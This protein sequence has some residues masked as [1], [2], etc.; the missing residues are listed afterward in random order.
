MEPQQRKLLELFTHAGIRPN[1]DF[2]NEQDTICKH[3]R[4]PG[5]EQYNRWEE[6]CWNKRGTMKSHK[7]YRYCIVANINNFKLSLK[8]A[9]YNLMKSNTNELREENINIKNYSNDNDNVLDDIFADISKLTNLIQEKQDKDNINQDE[10]SLIDR[11]NIITDSNILESIELSIHLNSKDGIR[12]ELELQYTKELK[13]FRFLSDNIKLRAKNIY[14]KMF[15][16]LEYIVLNN[17][18]LKESIP[19]ICSSFNKTY[20]EPV[21]IA[22]YIGSIDTN[23][24]LNKDSIYLYPID[25][26][27]I[28]N[29]DSK[30]IQLPIDSSRINIKF[31]PIID[32]QY[33]FPGQVVICQGINHIGN[34]FSINR[35]WY[36]TLPTIDSN[37]IIDIYKK[38]NNIVINKLFNI[39]FIQGPFIF[40]KCKDNI[41]VPDI[42]LHSLE[43]S[44]EK[45]YN[46]NELNTIIILG[47][48]ISDKIPTYCGYTYQELIY[49]LLEEIKIIIMK[50]YKKLLDILIIPSTKDLFIPHVFPQPSIN[51]I[52][53]NIETKLHCTCNPTIVIINGL[54]IGIMN[55][56][57][58]TSY[59]ENEQC[60]NNNNNSK[61]FN[62]N[63][64]EVIRAIYAMIN[65]K[66]FYP[67]FPPSSTCA[68]DYTSDITIDL[69]SV[70]I[71]I[72]SSEQKPFI[73]Y[74]LDT[75]VIVLK[76]SQENSKLFVSLL[77]NSSK[78][79]NII[80][81]EIGL[82]FTMNENL[83]TVL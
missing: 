53:K 2:I 70:D 19:I 78:Q 82:K 67:L 49:K 38:P 25:L 59:I 55:E 29:K 63:D 83:R 24:K 42:Q 35:I 54:R 48:L 31:N 1:E 4:I 80:L 27:Y 20:F 45:H 71:L 39:L 58:I 79:M 44:L 72:V 76:P 52:L 46:E 28:N 32:K 61:I 41:I 65:Q 40:Q 22:G 43:Y 75:I 13:N 81:N 60:V 57:F 47:P 3:F 62:K 68:I 12:D 26:S 17:I 77:S 23:Q 7:I 66:N 33:I 14:N 73:T 51:C 8:E 18:E 34:S 6:F 16:L 69:P 10:K 74:I 30:I 56:D 37:N 15:N 11:K 21:F 36:N 50:K 9:E 5:E 64:T